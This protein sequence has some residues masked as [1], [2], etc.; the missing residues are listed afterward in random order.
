M[1]CEENI[2]RMADSARALALQH[3]IDDI[4]SIKMGMSTPDEVIENYRKEV[5]EL[6]RRLGR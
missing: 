4:R 6:E 1:D 2:R 3:A 5:K